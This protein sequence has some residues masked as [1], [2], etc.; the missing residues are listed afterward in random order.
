M[1]VDNEG[2]RRPQD[3]FRGDDPANETDVEILEQ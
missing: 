3:R 2:S 1:A